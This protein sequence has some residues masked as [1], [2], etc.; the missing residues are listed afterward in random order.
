MLED[1]TKHEATDDFTR[2]IQEIIDF[3]H[4]D[5]KYEGQLYDFR[6]ENIRRNQIR[7]KD[8]P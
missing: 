1:G 3:F 8:S 2:K 4:M 5:D 7:K 6:D